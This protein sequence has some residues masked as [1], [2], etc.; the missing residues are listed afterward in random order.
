MKKNAFTTIELIFV[1]IILG[2]IAAFAIPRLALSRD[3]AYYVKIIN[4]IKQIM[5]D[6][7]S[8]VTSKGELPGDSQSF[9]SV[10]NVAFNGNTMIDGKS[11]PNIIFNTDK[12][13]LKFIFSKNTN[14]SII[15][16]LDP[17]TLATDC[18]TLDRNGALDNVKKTEY[19]ISSKEIR[20]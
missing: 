14:D 9:T 1:I 7:I 20:H 3:D 12:C 5:S 10:Q 18:I 11:Y 19:I 4:S 8:Y 15:I 6:M 2:L 13:M 16:K 17:A